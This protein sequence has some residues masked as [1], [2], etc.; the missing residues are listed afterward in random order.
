MLHS[1][2]VWAAV[3][4]VFKSRNMQ[5]RKCRPELVQAILARLGH[6]SRVYTCREAAVRGSMMS[7]ETARRLLEAVA[8][9]SDEIHFEGNS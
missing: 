4:G 1:R 7:S 9:S 2:R 5:T 3:S 6:I 8:N